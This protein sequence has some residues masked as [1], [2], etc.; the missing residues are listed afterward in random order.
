MTDKI[1]IIGNVGNDPQKTSTK[2]GDSVIRFDV[3]TNH[4]YF[5]KNTGTWVLKDTNWYSVSAFR[6][7]AENASASISRGDPVIV[8]GRLIQRDWEA[9]GKSG[10]NVDIEADTIALDLRRGT[11]SIQRKSG[12]SWAGRLGSWLVLAKTRSSSGGRVHLLNGSCA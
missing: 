10:T 2:S 9:N 5:D 1:T 11:G 3:A 12:L 7:L 8:I 4:R 6:Q